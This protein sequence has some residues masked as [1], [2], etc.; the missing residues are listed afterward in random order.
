MIPKLSLDGR[1]LLKTRDR[2]QRAG[3]GR[4]MLT[5]ISARAAS[6]KRP[7]FTPEGQAVS[8]PRHARQSSMCSM[9]DGLMGA[10]P[11]DTWAI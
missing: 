2:S 11:L 1:S 9:Y 5:S 7:Y 10:A 8:H 6:T 3:Q 4:R